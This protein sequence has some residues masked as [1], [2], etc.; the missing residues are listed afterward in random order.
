MERF[1]AK[2]LP[3]AELLS[4]G[5]HIAQCDACHGRFAEELRR[6]NPSTGVAFTLAPEFWFQYDHVDF[7]QLVGIAEKNLDELQQEIVNIHLQAC[8][9]CREDVRSFLEFRQKTSQEMRVSYAG[10]RSESL[11]PA[12]P[13]INWWPK[14]A[15][16]AAAVL[17]V[18]TAIVLVATLLRKRDTPIEAKK[19]EPS[20]IS[21]TPRP[22]PNSVNAFNPP[23]ASGT[24]LPKP[25]R[26]VSP[27][28]TNT[29]TTLTA[30][31]DESGDIHLNRDRQIAGLDSL[32]DMTRREIAEAVVEA[33]V[34]RPEVLN[35]LAAGDSSLRGNNTG[36]SFKLLSPQRL[37]IVEDRPTFRWQ[38]LPGATSYR[39][40]VGDARGHEAATSATLS[41]DTAEWTPPT[42]LN[43]GQIYSWSVVA[44]LDGKEIV[45]PGPSSPE[46]KFQ[47]LSDSS[48]KQLTEVKNTHSHLALGVFYSKVGLL[49]D[50]EQ[51]FQKLVQLN[52]QSQ[53]AANLLRSVRALR[54]SK[55]K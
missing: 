50:A 11:L 16:A 32:P 31:K 29:P 39:V 21:A 25:R 19:N 38:Q 30:L 7:D 18:I 46:M 20:Q 27:N 28:A 48:L 41:P 55:N 5:Q 40:Y 4:V 52:P 23:V 54:Q 6:F 35:E 3:E 9:K 15:L 17:L 49:A 14:P 47:I 43:R 36:P 1:C 44:V 10:I 34:N 2:T 45:S 37:V 8:E 24:E 51:E 12:K 53:V 13:S 33:K 26:E 22:T 42:R